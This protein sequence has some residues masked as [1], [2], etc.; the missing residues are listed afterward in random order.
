MM[1]LDEDER[2]PSSPL[3]DFVS[4][5][6][7]LLGLCREEPFKATDPVLDVRNRHRREFLDDIV[8]RVV[9]L[10]FAYRRNCELTAEYWKRDRKF[11]EDAGGPDKA[12]TITPEHQRA[13]DRWRS[14]ITLLSEHAAYEVTSIV[15]MLAEFEIRPRTGG[16]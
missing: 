11:W 16:E 9:L 12:A 15:S 6:R 13:E 8:G 14:E 10:A 1:P 3:D 4:K 7:D 2:P 5:A